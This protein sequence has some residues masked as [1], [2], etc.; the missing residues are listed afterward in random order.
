M[1]ALFKFPLPGRDSVVQTSRRAIAPSSFGV[2]ETTLGPEYGAHSIYGGARRAEL[3]FRGSFFKCTNHDWKTN[4]INGCVIPSGRTSMTQPMLSQNAATPAYF[5]PMSSRRPN[6]PYRLA[7]KIVSSFTGMLFSHGRW[8]QMRSDDPI[9]QDWAEEISKA[10]K[11]QQAMIRARNSGG[12][13]G[14]V[15]MSWGWIDGRPRV[16]VH[17]G[18]LLHC[19]EWSE[20]DDQIPRHVTELYKFQ[21]QVINK[22]GKAEL[23]D[24]WHRRDWTDLADVVFHDCE[25]TD[26][27]PAWL[28]D[29]EKSFLHNHG[30]IHFEW[31]ANAP[32]DEVDS[33]DGQ[34]DYPET[35]EQLNT[36]DI[37]NSVVVMGSIRNLDPTLVVKAEADLLGNVIRKGS[38]NA[39]TPGVNGDAKYLELSG[40]TISAGMTLVD[41]EV[42]QILDTCECILTDPDKL[43][44]SGMSS[45]ALKI[46]Y[47]PM[48]AKCDIMRP[49]YGGAIQRILDGLTDFARL[50]M[51]GVPGEQILMP[52]QSDEEEE[53]QVDEAGNTIEPEEKTEPVEFFFNLPRRQVETPVLDENGSP[54]G[55]QTVTEEEREP[56]TG[57]IVVEWGEYFTPTADDIQ[58]T[59]SAISQAAGGKSVMSQRTAVELTA[60]LY[61]RDANQEWIDVSKENADARAHELA[62]NAGMFPGTGGQVDP[63]SSG[64]TH[65]DDAPSEDALTDEAILDELTVNEAREIRGRKP[66]TLQDGSLNP[67]GFLPIAQYKSKVAAMGTVD[68]ETEAG[69]PPV[70]AP[71]TQPQGN[72]PGEPGLTQAPF[73]GGVSVTPAP[74]AKAPPPAVPQPKSPPPPEEK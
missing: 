11:L 21:K 40:T 61:N 64:L 24:F 71:P 54:T 6:N 37:T 69:A 19:L 27:E 47:A 7:R 29:E 2:D 53:P 63:D 73:G 74:K 18:K 65:K 50:H 72:V 5:V 44:A 22:K 68:G 36:L 59:T 10:C 46:I 4:D 51:P 43:A 28:I 70:E 35:Y 1:A 45:V 58:K 60:N 67:D 17:E 26:N 3:E 42:Q 13:C 15:G 49:Q 23:V 33:C 56:G 8:P 57:A 39:I 32:G 48:I 14:V 38:D 66:L 55:E 25:V 62:S 12:S 20:E 30:R 41:K 9:T 31:I 16:R 52:V 34:P